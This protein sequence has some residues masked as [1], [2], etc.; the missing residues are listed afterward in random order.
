MKTP[1]APPEIKPKMSLSFRM[2]AWLLSGLALAAL[3]YGIALWVKRPP[4]PPPARTSVLLITLDTTRADRLGA[5]GSAAGLTPTLDAFAAKSAL[6][7]ACE[8]AVPTTL[9]AHATLLSGLLPARH[10]V[11]VNRANP[12]PT[13]VPLVQEAFAAAGYRTAAFVSAPVLLPR[14]GLG[15]GFGLYETSGLESAGGPENQTVT[16]DRTLAQAARWIES[17]PRPFFAWVH[18]FDPHHPYTPPEPFASRYG[19]APYDGEVAFMDDQLG[20]F[21][22]RLA[23]LRPEGWAIVICGDHGE[24]LGDHGED[25][26]GTLL[27]EATTR[28]PL[29]IQAPGQATPRRVLQP[30]GLVDLAATLAE[31]GGTAFPAGDGRSLAPLMRGE[32]LPEKPVLMESLSGMYS[33]GWAP[34]FAAREGAL[35][36]I[37]APRAELYD[38]AKDPLE[39]TNLLGPGTSAPEGLRRAVAAYQKL[40]P[41][42]TSN[43]EALSQEEM[44]QLASL[45]YLSAGFAGATKA[46]RDP[47]D[48]VHLWPDFNRATALATGGKPQEA[49]E[50][51]RRLE[52]EDPGNPYV[53]FLEGIALQQGDPDGAEEAFRKAVR[54]EPSYEMA[55]ANWAALRLKRGNLEGAAAV[56]RLALENA[57]DVS[58]YLN[59]ALAEQAFVQNKGEAEVLARIDDALAANPSLARA[60]LLKGV[61]LLRAG[62]PAEAQ[63]AMEKV[64]SLATRAEVEAWSN[65][66]AFKEVFA[67]RPPS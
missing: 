10:S 43:K 1:P 4:S 39:A 47:K 33:C 45:G 48:V 25:Q 50:I 53:P 11:R 40:L 18:L 20:A 21:F 66:P 54:L 26:H 65:S 6:F 5:Y 32:A 64:W 22:R 55:W 14:F 59:L 62:R 51:L 63:A 34:L 38:L 37:D 35:K 16:A 12:V 42:A 15:R 2:L 52:G 61:T 19:A 49:L 3:S 9:P 8:T 41:V 13:E 7:E 67:G 31:L 56:A 30:V 29:L 36:H 44:R 57:R 23:P 27:Y 60:H 58:G 17:D 46:R 24:G 28:V